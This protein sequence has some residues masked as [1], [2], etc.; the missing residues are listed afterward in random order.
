M[1]PFI[2]LFFSFVLCV[3]CSGQNKYTRFIEKSNV[4]WAQDVTDTFRFT[5]PNLSLL[6]RQQLAKEKIKVA[7]VEPGSSRIPD[8]RFVKKMDVIQTIAPNR[9]VQ[10]VDAE[11][12]NAGIVREAEDPLLSSRYFDWETHAKLEVAQVF[13]VQCGRLKSYVPWVSPKYTITTSWGE[14]LGIANAFSTAFGTS[15]KF[16][17]RSKKKAQLLGTHTQTIRMDSAGSATMLKQLYGQ[18]L[19]QALWPHLGKKYYQLRLPGSNEAIPFSKINQ[20]LIEENPVAIPVYDAEGNVTTKGIVLQESQP[21]DLRQITAIDIVQDW[22]YVA[23]TNR[24]YS[25]VSEIVL[26]AIR[27]KAGVS[28]AGASPILSIVV[29]Q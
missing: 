14:R 6:L 5:N 7:V 13:Y 16:S 18:N 12:N 1:K 29:K 19:A 26:Y 23:R 10:V 17:S 9:E 27:S 25:T 24:V 20:T 22:Y 28:D 21:L 2:L 11:G 15:R 8:I 3:V 4:L